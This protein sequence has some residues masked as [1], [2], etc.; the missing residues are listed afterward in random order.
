M[1]LRIFLDFTKGESNAQLL[2]C[3]KQ[4]EDKTSCLDE[5]TKSITG[6]KYDSISPVLAEFPPCKLESRN[7]S[8]VTS[9]LIL[10]QN[11]GGTTP[12]SLTIEQNRLP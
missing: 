8:V 11:Q 12:R 9:D 1:S 7:P 10:S 2:A 4:D 3:P 5:Q 6:D